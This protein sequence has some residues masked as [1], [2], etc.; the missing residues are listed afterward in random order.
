[1]ETS[2]IKYPEIPPRK[3]TNKVK[4]FN[5]QDRHTIKGLGNINHPSKDPPIT[6]II[7]KPNILLDIPQLSSFK[8]LSELSLNP[9][10][11]E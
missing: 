7:I 1:M 11:R 10:D 5:S 9:P 4:F 6:A 8:Q 3:H 2:L